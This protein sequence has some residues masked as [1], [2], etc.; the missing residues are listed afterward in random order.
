VKKVPLVLAAALVACS[1][2]AA[3]A[4]PSPARAA[5]PSPTP[6]RTTPS[7]VAAP[8]AIARAPGAV[9]YVAIGASDTVGI[10]SL[11]PV[12]GS[13]PARIAALLPA[14][15]TYANL[16]VSGSLAAQAQRE[17]LPS[18]IREQP[19]VA[20]VWLAV[21]DLNFGV[22]PQDHAAA[23]GA[24][25]DGLVQATPAKV[26]VGNVP[27]LRAVPVYAAI[28]PAIL[29][30]RVTA[31]NAGIAAVAAKHPGRVVVVDLF[32]GSADLVTQIT[33][34]QDGFHPSDAGYVLI[35]QR[36]AEA[37]RKT[38]IALRAG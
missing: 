3:V 27:D 31:F 14:G 6:V 7:P 18:G 21:N 25:V 35:A 8:T 26:F 24:I 38:G 1:S 4:S 16:G 17:Q 15:G 5:T 10:G 19:T 34:A 11:D 37:M 30:A 2:P 32:T 20:T 23:L 12:Q 33:V 28:D 36:F 22:P 13:W 9:H 29:L